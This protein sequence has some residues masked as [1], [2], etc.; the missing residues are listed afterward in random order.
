MLSAMYGVSVNLTGAEWQHI[1]QARQK[2]LPNENLSRSEVVRRYA[3]A[4]ID[5][6]KQ[7]SSADGARLAHSHQVSVEA[8]ERLRQ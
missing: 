4:G 5:T 1:Q 7:L 2:A 3:R 8:E 6:L